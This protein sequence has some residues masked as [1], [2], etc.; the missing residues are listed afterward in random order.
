MADKKPLLDAVKDRRTFY[1]LSKETTISNERIKELVE[2]T[3]K[4]APSAFNV[5]VRSSLHIPQ[6]DVR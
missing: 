3:I 5:Q 1:K 6:E 2:Y 4:H